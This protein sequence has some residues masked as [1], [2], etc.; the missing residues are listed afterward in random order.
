M[1][2]EYIPA[3]VSAGLLFSV[4]MSWEHLNASDCPS[5]HV[6]FNVKFTSTFRM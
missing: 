4:P 6:V 1:N 5:S 3:F 2:G